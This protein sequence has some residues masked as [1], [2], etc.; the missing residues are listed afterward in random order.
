VIVPIGL[1]GV[2]LGWLSRRYQRL[3]PNMVAHAFFNLLPVIG[4]ILAQALT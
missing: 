3:G 2:V 4:L 1:T